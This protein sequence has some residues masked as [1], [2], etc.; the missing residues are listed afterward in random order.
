MFTTPEAKNVRNETTIP[1]KPRTKAIL[2][3][4]Q[5]VLR[6]F[7]QPRNLKN[8]MQ[9]LG[10]FQPNNMRKNPK[11]ICGFPK[12]LTVTLKCKREA[13]QILQAKSIDSEMLGNTNPE[14]K[15]LG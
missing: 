15:A 11:K 10:F 9:V 12:C 14:S 5:N 6:E 4:V 13:F 2:R 8:D 1:K 3:Q 7:P